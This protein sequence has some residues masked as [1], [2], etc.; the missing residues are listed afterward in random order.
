MPTITP[1]TERTMMLRRARCVLSHPG[2]L[3]V[4]SRGQLA[5]VAFI[6]DRPELLKQAGF[7]MSQALGR[8]D[9]VEIDAIEFAAWHLHDPCFD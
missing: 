9:Q 3:N 7:T 6:L 4:M 2:T 1:I 8:F 5:A